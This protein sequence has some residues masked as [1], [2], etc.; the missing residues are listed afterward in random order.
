MLQ[1]TFFYT[2]Q[3]LRL[4]IYVIKKYSLML[5][6]FRF[7]RTSYNFLGHIFF[8][9]Q[10]SCSHSDHGSLI[11]ICVIV[12][13]PDQRS[14]CRSW[15]PVLANDCEWLST[16]KVS[17]AIS[18]LTCFVFFYLF[19]HCHLSIMYGKHEKAT[20]YNILSLF[21]VSRSCTSLIL[22][23]DFTARRC[24]SVHSHTSLR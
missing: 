17:L 11:S 14:V 1:L 18:M 24:T 23:N 19:H 5:N 8:T 15:Q 13:E 16:G 7:G 22:E 20:K 21:G 6:A 2:L 3:C 12:C 10:C 4:A 9:L